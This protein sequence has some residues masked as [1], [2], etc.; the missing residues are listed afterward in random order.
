MCDVRALNLRC[1]Y[2]RAVAMAAMD[3]EAGEM[4][5]SDCLA[6]VAVLAFNVS[7]DGPQD[8]PAL[9]ADVPSMVAAW[10]Y[11]VEL[12]SSHDAQEDAD[13]G[14]EA[15]SWAVQTWESG[16]WLTTPYPTLDDAMTAFLIAPES[17]NARLTFGGEIGM[18]SAADDADTVCT[19]P[20]HLARQMLDAHDRIYQILS[21]DQKGV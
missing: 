6:D 9:L 14:A 8:V 7:E 5:V 19:L 11:G 10:E 3:A 15:P 1:A 16:D 2:A 17:A 20:A 13:E 18:A 12:A 4:A 21:H